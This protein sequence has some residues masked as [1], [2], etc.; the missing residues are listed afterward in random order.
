MATDAPPQRRK[1][2]K[3]SFVKWLKRS[4][5][6]GAA[7]GLLAMI[8]VAFLPK[9]VLVDV[10][11]VER[12]PLRV[13]VDEDGRSRVSDR[14]VLSAPL[15]GNLGRIELDPGDPVSEG[16]VLA[17]LV[18]LARPLMDAQ[19]RAEAEAR[20]A[21]SAAQLRQARASVER[22][23]AALTFAETQVGRHQ[24]LVQRGTL[25]QEALDRV[26][27][28]RR[29][30]R[31]EL[32]SAE[33]GVRVA[34]HQLEMARA[35]LGRFDQGEDAG[36]QMEVTS[37]IEGQVLRVMHES[38]G[39]VQA[40]TPLLELGDPSHL[41]I[42]VDVLTSDAVQIEPGQRVIVERWG[43][44]PLDAHVRLIEPSAFTRTSALGVEEQRI[45]VVIDLDSPGEAWQRL[46]DGY[47]V[48]TQIV[49]WEEADVLRV[50]A[51][52]VFRHAG[53]WAVYAI[54]GGVARLTPVETGRR[55]GLEVQILGGVEEGD[56]LVAH[57]SDQVTDGTPVEAR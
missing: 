6:I 2:G 32:T 13:T 41:E 37:P 28:E 34:A 54:E 53:G 3:R 51:N 40:G 42:A 10:A 29:S 19:S 57:P 1:N 22:G 4:L 23:R 50:P 18:P 33:F 8:V 52:A 36:E 45:N 48:E 21:A 16:A 44:D 5:W 31:E 55:N 7:L 20:V 25:A 12:G 11:L 47:R 56:R 49:I 39:V 38:A 24:R 46:G 26:E 9:P 35:A 27:L 15:T 14:Y 30:R 43:G 17:R